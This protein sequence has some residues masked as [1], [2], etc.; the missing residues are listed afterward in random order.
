MTGGGD[1]EEGWINGDGR[2]LKNYVSVEKCDYLVIDGLT[3]IY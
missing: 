3:I 1:Y 2:E